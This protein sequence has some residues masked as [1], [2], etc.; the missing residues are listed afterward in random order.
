MKLGQN[1]EIDQNWAKIMKLG[2]K[3]EI[4]KNW[5]KIIK[6]IKIETKFWN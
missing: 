4:D 5:D 2:Q 1:Y 6:L 3:Y